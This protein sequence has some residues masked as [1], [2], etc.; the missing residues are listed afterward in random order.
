MKSLFVSIYII[1]SCVA[2]SGAEIYDIQTDKARYAPGESVQF[3]VT[4]T[5]A[6]SASSSCTIIGTASHRISHVAD[7][8]SDAYILEPYKTHTY[9]F[10]WQP[11]LRDFTGYLIEMRVVSE[12]TTSAHINTAVDVSSDW[13]VFPRYG[14]ISSYGSMSASEIQKTI[15]KL[16]DYHING[17]QFYD[18]QNYK[19]HIPLAGTVSQPDAMW[20]DIANR[21]NYYL[22]MYRYISAAHSRNMMCMNYNL[23]Y[24]ASADGYSDGLQQEWGLYDDASHTTQATHGLPNDWA[25]P[26]I[27]VFNPLDSDWQN[28]IL[29]EEQK[30]FS[31]FDFDGWH[32]D[33]LGKNGYDWN[34]NYINM[35]PAYNTFLTVAKNKL[36]VR[37]TF[38]AVT[39]WG[40]PETLNNVDF[41]YVE[42]W[43]DAGDTYRRYLGFQWM[44]DHC[45]NWSDNMKNIVFAA[46]V[47]RTASEIHLPSVLLSDAA[48]FSTGGAHLELG[49][50]GLLSHEYFPVDKPE[51]DELMSQLCDYY[52]VATAYQNLLRDRDVVAISRDVTSSTFPVSNWDKPGHVWCFAKQK[53][54]DE[55]VHLINLT[56][57]TT[58]LWNDTNG[59]Y[60]AAPIYSNATVR[61]YT[62][63]RIDSVYMISPDFAHG[64]VVDVSFTTH[65]TGGNTYVEC[66]LPYLEY[67]SML[68]LRT[69]PSTYYISKNATH[70]FDGSSIETAFP[71][72]YDADQSI[73]YVNGDT[74]LIDAGTV[75]GER[76]FIYD[77]G[78]PAGAISRFEILRD[79]TTAND[80]TIAGINGIPVIAAEYPPIQFHGV[81]YNC[82]VSNCA[83]VISNG[84]AI[85][86][87]NQ[88]S[89]AYDPDVGESARWYP[90]SGGNI[91]IIHC[92]I[93]NLLASP[94]IVFGVNGSFD[95]R[96]NAD[97]YTQLKGTR[98]LSN[99]IACTGTG[100]IPGAIRFNTYG[101]GAGVVIEGNTLCGAGMATAGTAD[102]IRVEWNDGKDTG[103]S[104]HKNHIHDFSA[105]ALALD[106][107][108]SDIRENLIWDI[109]GPGI[110]IDGGVASGTPNTCVNNTLWNI[111]GNCVF[112][113]Y[114]STATNWWINN[115][116][117][118]ATTGAYAIW[119]DGGA[120]NMCAGN[121][122]FDIAETYNTDVTESEIN[123]WYTN[124]VVLST[125][126]N[127]NVFL[128][129]AYPVSSTTALYGGSSLYN[130][131]EWLGVGGGVQGGPPL[132]IP[133]PSMFLACVYLVTVLIKNR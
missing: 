131:Y 28:W 107:G 6:S 110:Q 4:V 45:R 34:G 102:G 124:P 104:I 94:A 88:A 61:V 67:W 51:S 54:N 117:I 23:L 53:R 115:M 84:P 26:Y 93:S 112:T 72:I 80:I 65:T 39:E 121:L 13:K 7:M 21:D 96:E 47:N 113:R 50:H 114:D 59:V 132:D 130:G 126:R 74:L 101:G 116:F 78:G 35:A 90:A 36:P 120:L 62:D 66:S 122:S 77:S 82:V 76:G 24:G 43:P 79:S 18:W 133:E 119:S 46:Y 128:A 56:S 123:Y 87:A 22:T 108:A 37:Y 2:L 71:T 30:V 52:H 41:E 17:I 58:N 125:Q 32:V 1:F 38:N 85:A 19:H 3:S 60:P 31:V 106:I 118:T 99:D 12:N 68:I 42:V 16:N 15:E 81:R 10:S 57:L 95:N 111:G 27:M 8:Q 89:Y 83:F 98:I 109:G 75:Q 64:S 70:T 9:T 103:Y 5:N 86:V 129:L 127:D 69:E 97:V 40:A 63:T 100:D 14:Y 44:F 91:E 20:K 105:R 73:D 25:T 48:I 49:D 92:S 55:I 33:Q 29:S 11:P